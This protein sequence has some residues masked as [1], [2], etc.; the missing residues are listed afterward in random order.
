MRVRYLGVGICLGLVIGLSFG[1]YFG[2]ASKSTYKTVESDVIQMEVTVTIP[3]ET[4][5]ERTTR[6]YREMNERVAQDIKDL[7]ELE[8]LIDNER[9]I[10][11]QIAD[12]LGKNQPAPAKLVDELKSLENAIDAKLRQMEQRPH[13]TTPPV[14]LKHPE[15]R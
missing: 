14:P 12:P 15:K 2:R 10:L 9:Q 5:Q 3:D 13:I 4:E 6:E 1:A 11:L 7:A 8:D